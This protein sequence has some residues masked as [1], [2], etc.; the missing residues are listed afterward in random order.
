M[1]ICPTC[2]QEVHCPHKESP[3][4]VPCGHNMILSGAM[5]QTFIDGK[6]HKQ[7]LRK[8][9]YY[10]R[11]C[12]HTTVAPS[13]GCKREEPEK[14]LKYPHT[15]PRCG[16]APTVCPKCGYAPM[17]KGG[18]SRY[19]TADYKTHTIQMWKCPRCGKATAN[20]VCPCSDKNPDKAYRSKVL[21]ALEDSGRYS[22][23][24]ESDSSI[25]ESLLPKISVKGSR[26]HADE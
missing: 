15:C 26:A 2:N 22:P 3:N 25:P 10:C 16:M 4:S 9:K 14:I 20:P 13:C 24:V 8:P 19:T 12:G 17:M 21:K 7:T 11:L 23:E 18:N 5:I 6:G 1:A